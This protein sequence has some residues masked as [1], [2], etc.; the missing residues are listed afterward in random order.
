MCGGVPTAAVAPSPK[1]QAYAA[2]VPSGSL[3]AEPSNDAFSP[4]AAEVNDAVGA[5]LGKVPPPAL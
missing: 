4:E 1:S 3:D 2:I 5:W